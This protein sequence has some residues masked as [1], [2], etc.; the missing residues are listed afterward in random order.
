M[1][2]H[3]VAALSL[4]GLLTGAV[5][6]A[7]PRPKASELLKKVRSAY[8]SLQS[9]RDQGEIEA[10]Y[11]FTGA[12]E[13]HRFDL[14]M[15]A[16]GGYRFTLQDVD[17][18]GSPST[19]V[20]RDGAQVSVFDSK[21]GTPRTA[22]SLLSE[23]VRSYG[24]GGLDA[25]VVPAFLAGA[26]DVL[27]APTAATVEGPEPCGDEGPDRCWILAL[28]REGGLT[29]RLWVDTATS[30]VRQAEVRLPAGSKRSRIRVLHERP[31]AN[32][33]LTA[34]DLT[35]AGPPP[36]AEP[37]SEMVASAT[38]GSATEP[39]KA[40]ADG[41][42]RI[43]P[44]EMFQ[45]EVTVAVR[46]L[47]VRVVSGNGEPLLGLKPEDFVV[48]AGKKEI[49][50]L[51]VDWTSNAEVFPEEET[52]TEP[53][54]AT[55]S[56]GVTLLRKAGPP[57]GKLVLFFVQADLEPSR[58]KG[59]MA[60]LPRVEKLL[61]TL[62][63]GD[64]L[65][66]VS[67]DHKLRLRLDWTLN[68]DD[69]REALRRTVRT[70]GEFSISSGDSPQVASLTRFFDEDAAAKAANPERA[71]EVVAETLAAYPGEKVVVFIGWGLGRFTMDGM[72]YTQTFKRAA[73]KLNEARATVFVL[74]VTHA[75]YHSLS[76]GLKTMAVT[77]GGTYASTYTFPDQAI[78]QLAQAISGYYVLTL[79]ADDLPRGESLRI[80]LRDK[81]K[82][83]VL[84][85]PAAVSSAV[86]RGSQ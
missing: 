3:Q 60:L 38:L 18:P 24:E 7:Q 59:H 34:A 81:K 67:F 84:V 71:L 53:G 29:S 77:T 2:P 13:R 85:R 46:P 80:E 51:A 12:I 26:T 79:D 63:R 73:E 43:R 33:P 57:P 35:F 86:V 23:V 83:M 65:A 36:P 52:A 70:G 82:G 74:D 39:P 19:V 48:R 55:P 30:L 17:S 1:N 31:A 41:L 22:K 14:A 11:S 58:I 21:A 62:E 61:N 49:P 28:A 54:A 50:V 69:L 25:L 42:S 20:W 40:P 6:E 56:P 76:A 5:L 27:S 37:V 10:V 9:F 78:Q 66:L 44:E 45:S 16:G 47:V 68:R 8:S 72:R 4:A 75:D 15:S 64:Q 32:P